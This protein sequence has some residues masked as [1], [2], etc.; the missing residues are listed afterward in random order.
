MVRYKMLGRDI[1]S[2]PVQYRTWVVNNTPD[3]TG[4]LY[5]GHKS[6]PHPFVDVVAYAIF[7]PEPI[8]FN[9]PDP[10]N[11]I[12][13]KKV[14]PGHVC[15]GQLAIIDGYVYL[16]GG[17][18]S[19]KIYRATL[20]NPT[21]W[22]DTGATLPTNLAGSQLAIIGNTIYLFGGTTDATLFNS[23]NNIYS[24][25]VSNPLSWTDNGPKLPLK[26]HHS[27]LAIVDGYI[28]L[29]G[30][31]DEENA[32]D[33]IVKSHS[34]NP[35]SWSNTGQKIPDKL[36]ASQLAILDG[37]VCLFGGMLP[38]NDSTAK[39]Y[40]APLNNPTS[41]LFS[42]LLPYPAAY[43]Q[44]VA[45][46]TKG[47]LITPTKSSTSNTN[48]LQCDVHTPTLW[49]DTKSTLPGNA[50][51]S[52]LAIIND[53]LFLFGGNGSTIIFANN[54]ILKFPLYSPDTL[55]YGFVTRTEYNAT[56]NPLDLFMVIGFPNWKTDYGS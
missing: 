14:L 20:D 42:G 51:Q 13:T 43:G 56:L 52:H 30:G 45:V 27:Q 28:Y 23:T 38:N 46:G 15:D 35:L 12:S 11:W 29:F 26:L 6:G 44:F 9:L 25:P 40:L 2:T 37:Y 24:A 21:D 48:I 4:A 8:D 3:Y 17:Q 54:Q 7:D 39:I 16:F 53:R 22:V 19:A 10:L 32:T 5:T 33:A 1:D 50:S 47:Y 31:H 36:Y 55:S 18:N 49:V 34:S 41:W